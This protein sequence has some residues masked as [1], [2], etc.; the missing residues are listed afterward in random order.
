MRHVFLLGLFLASTIFSFAQEKTAQQAEKT[1]KKNEQRIKVMVNQDGKQIKIDTIFNLPDEKMIQF[2]V[3]SLLQKL[4]VNNGKAGEPNIVILRGGKGMNMSHHHA[5]GMPG[6]NQIELIYQKGDS[7]QVQNVR[8][9]IRIRGENMETVDVAGDMEPPMPPM[10]PVPPFHMRGF[11]MSTGDDP[12]AMDPDDKD[13]VTYD[14]KDLGKGLEKIT[15]VRRKH[16]PEADAKEVQV[17][18]EVDDQKKK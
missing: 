13:I 3:D 5:D 16:T 1:T 7:G 12:F 17:K 11:K 8:K 15:I 10:P 18:V 4:G 9:V 6:E 14:K 2:K